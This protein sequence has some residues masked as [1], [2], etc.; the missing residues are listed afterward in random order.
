MLVRGPRHPL[1]LD[2]ARSTGHLQRS[3]HSA[4]NLSQTEHQ[5][6]C[7]GLTPPGINCATS[8]SCRRCRP[9]AGTVLGLLGKVFSPHPHILKVHGTTASVLQ[10]RKLRRRGAKNLPKVIQRGQAT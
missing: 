5:M 3:G 6:C 10:T 1:T 2:A 8:T 9:E 7:K 4:V